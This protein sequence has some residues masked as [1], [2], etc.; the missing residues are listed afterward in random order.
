MGR[1]F[2]VFMLG[3]MMSMQLFACNINTASVE[4]LSALKGI[5]Q[6]TA[7]KIVEYRSEHR[8]T[9]IEDLMKVKGIGQKKFDSI[10][11]DLSV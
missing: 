8:F 1:K 11:K 3:M 10:K 6:S 5:G 7:K 9:T 4:E 2:L